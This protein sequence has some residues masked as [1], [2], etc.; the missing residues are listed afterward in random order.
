MYTKIGFVQ[1]DQR[2]SGLFRS[3]GYVGQM[4]YVLEIFTVRN[5]VAA[6]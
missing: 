5:V 3:T 1:T 4:R 6:R 2:I